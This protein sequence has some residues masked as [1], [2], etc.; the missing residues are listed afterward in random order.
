MAGI[1]GDG[2]CVRT[3]AVPVEFREHRILMGIEFDESDIHRIE[4]F[5]ACWHRLK[6]SLPNSSESACLPCLTVAYDLCQ[7]LSI[8]VAHD[9]TP[10]Y[11][12]VTK[13]EENKTD[14]FGIVNC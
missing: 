2:M 13:Q 12:D 14:A 1:H 6:D 4:Y 5:N 10:E 11:I 3:L 7:M 8:V 9:D